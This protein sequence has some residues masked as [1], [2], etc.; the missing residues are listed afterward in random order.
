M[1]QQK[2]TQMKRE[3]KVNIINNDGVYYFSLYDI[4]DC[5]VLF[6]AISK[7]KEDETI[8]KFIIKINE[9]MSNQIKDGLYLYH[10][11]VLPD[12]DYYINNRLVELLIKDYDKNENTHKLIY[13]FSFLENYEDEIFI[14]ENIF[15]FNTD[16]I[17]ND[18]KNKTSRLVKKT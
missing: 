6:K 11:V 12:Y 7:K 18:S 16:I 3:P 8:D 9:I 13:Q 10:I 2:R 5:L 17:W 4:V 1:K 15:E 14:K